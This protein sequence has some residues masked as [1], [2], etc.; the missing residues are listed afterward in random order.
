MFGWQLYSQFKLKYSQCWGFWIHK[1]CHFYHP[2]LGMVIIPPIKMVIF[3]DG[4]HGLVL[5]IF[6]CFFFLP[7]LERFPKAKHLPKVRALPPALLSAAAAH[8]GS[9][10]EGIRTERLC[11]VCWK[12]N[13][14]WGGK[15]W[16]NPSIYSNDF[17][18]MQPMVEQNIYN[19]YPQNWLIFKANVGQYTST[20]GL[21]W[22]YDTRGDRKTWLEMEVNTDVMTS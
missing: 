15:P 4:K 17:T 22:P 20:M 3:L 13:W 7:P 9:Q 5:S 1:Q 14:I 6:S 19:I 8:Q 16:E 12:E 11:R 21:F 2:W 10:G 18:H